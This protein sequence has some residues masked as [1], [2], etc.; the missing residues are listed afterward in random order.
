MARLGS[1]APSTWARLFVLRGRLSRST[2][3]ALGA[4]AFT[5]LLG[6]WSLAAALQ[7]L[8]PQYLPSPRAIVEA[9]VRLFVDFDFANDIYISV[10]RVA[11]AFALAAFMAIPIGI[12]MSSY[13]VIGAMSEPVVDLIRYLPVPALVPLTV[14]WLGVGEESKIALLWMGTFFQL[15][16]LVADDTKRVP[17]EYVETAY[18]VGAKQRHVLSHIIFP[19]ILPSLVDNLRITLGWCW[20]YVILAEIVA[21]NEGI[22]HIIWASRRFGKTPEVM[23]GVLTIGLIGLLSDQLIRLLH[24]RAFRYLTK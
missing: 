15:V 4:L 6:A 7:I 14:I 22:G 23:A 1:P 19:G 17:Q 13:N 12:L 18:T 21:A 10:V 9:L 24:R 5:L 11:I 8:P 20:S 3:L 16:L 2:T